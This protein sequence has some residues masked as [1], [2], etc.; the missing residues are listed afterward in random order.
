MP[1][2]S[3]KTKGEV[4]KC[5]CGGG[6]EYNFLVWQK[7]LA[8]GVAGWEMCLQLIPFLKDFQFE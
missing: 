5:V 3:A 1:S 8:D 6:G 4:T 7:F 2:L